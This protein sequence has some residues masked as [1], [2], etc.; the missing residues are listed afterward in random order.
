M[1]IDNSPDGTHSVVAGTAAFISDF[2]STNP[3][4]NNTLPSYLPLNDLTISHPFN[5]STT[6]DTLDNIAVNY[7]RLGNTSSLLNPSAEHWYPSCSSSLVIGD[8]TM[9]V[10]KSIPNNHYMEGY[11]DTSDTNPL[12]EF[13]L[14]TKRT[15]SNQ[16]T[17]RLPPS[18]RMMPTYWN[19]DF[20]RQQIDSPVDLRVRFK[21]RMLATACHVTSTTDTY[22]PHAQ[23]SDI[24]ESLPCTRSLETKTT[25]L[26]ETPY[27]TYFH[28]DSE[29][30]PSAPPVTL[31]CGVVVPENH[32]QFPQYQLDK[33]LPG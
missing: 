18:K 20:T 23:E 33:I 17:G 10:D 29:H 27:T 12:Q 6:L 11:S 16:N 19:P 30:Y 14:P 1:D 25:N 31:T 13:A 3:N 7:S 8:A 28:L 4:F 9:D 15:R 21:G 24:M 5:S 32:C 26:G 2:S 22:F